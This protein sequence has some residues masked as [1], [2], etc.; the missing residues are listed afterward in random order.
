VALNSVNTNIGAQVALASLDATTSALHVVQ[1]QVSTGY[2]VADAV[3]N[4]AAYA[5]AQRVR[6][7]VGALTAAN[8]ELGNAQGLLDVTSSSLNDI[9]NTLNSARAVLV[10]LSDGNTTGAQ[11]TQ[12]ASQYQQL[13]AQV[14]GYINDSA[15]DAKSLINNLTSAS[16]G[17]PNAIYSINVSRNESGGTYNLATYSGSALY[18]AITFTASVNST[19]PTAQAAIAALLTTGGSFISQLTSVATALNK[20]GAETNY[21]GNQISYNSDKINALNTGLGALVDADLAQESAQ[22][23]SLQIKQQLG[24]QALTIANQAPLTLLKLYG[25]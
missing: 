15:Y 8:T 21:L 4:G 7:D 23:Q 20:Y 16:T 25:G 2:K 1:K 11:R 13:V 22:L 12:Y 3:D 10:S 19:S 17:T 9:S 14:R 18:N 24:T 6:S 5:V